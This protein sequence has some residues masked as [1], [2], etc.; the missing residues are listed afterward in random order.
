[1][2]IAHVRRRLTVGAELQ[3]DGTAHARVWAPACRRVEAMVEPRSGGARRTVPLDREGDGY[4]SGIVPDV[5]QGDRYWYRL[6][7]DRL[8]P[9]PASRFQPEGPH[10]PSAFVDPLTFEWTDGRWQGVAREG[11]VLYEMHVG[12]FT[13]EGTWAA[14]AT[15]LEELATLGITVI[16][17]M[18]VADFAGRFGWGYDGVNLYAPTRLYG[19]PDDLRAFIDRAHGLRLGVILDVVYNHF[20][21]D[22][23]FMEEFSPE[24]FT[25]AAMTAAGR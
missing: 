6:D 16:E 20:G 4:F 7:G 19:T 24:Y 15:Q 10:G 11:Q 23:N 5:R 8:R 3:S 13:R 25:V 2:T 17:M 14:A 12:T 9:D 1:M 22:G 21:P 18:P